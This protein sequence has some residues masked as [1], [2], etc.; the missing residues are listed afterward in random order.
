MKKLLTYLPTTML[1]AAIFALSSITVTFAS[2][3]AENSIKALN[4]TFKTKS[5]QVDG[6][7]TELTK[8]VPEHKASQLS[9]KTLENVSWRTGLVK[10]SRKPANDI[11]DA[12]NKALEGQTYTTGVDDQEAFKNEWQQNKAT[13]L[14]VASFLAASEYLAKADMSE[15][16]NDKSVWNTNVEATK[17]L[18]DVITDQD[19]KNFQVIFLTNRISALKD[20]SAS[21]TKQEKHMDNIIT[22]RTNLLAQ[23]SSAKVKAIWKKNGTLEAEEDAKAEVKKELVEGRVE[24][25]QVEKKELTPIERRILYKKKREN[26]KK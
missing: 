4:K 14:K 16:G 8:R 5:S 22:K 9:V 20:L 21:L 13:K 23:A 25:E 1:F 3:E 17:A 6:K 2:E 19:N 12:H 15:E 11:I 26:K 7:I 24:E 10:Q 18:A